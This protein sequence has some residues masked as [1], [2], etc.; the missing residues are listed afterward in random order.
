MVVGSLLFGLGTAGSCPA[1]LTEGNEGKPR[2]VP[3]T[4]AG[5]LRK[6]R[7]PRENKFRGKKRAG[8]RPRRLDVF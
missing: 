1:G 3:G 5:G 6:F 4:S 7:V 8:A 2:L